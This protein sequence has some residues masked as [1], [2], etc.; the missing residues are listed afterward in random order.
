LTDQV[1]SVHVQA[2]Q[3]LLKYQDHKPYL[4]RRS[5]LQNALRKFSQGEV[6]YSK[7]KDGCLIW[8][9]WKKKAKGD[10]RYRNFPKGIQLPPESE[11]LYDFYLHSIYGDKKMFYNNLIH[12]IKK[13]QHPGTK[14]LLV[15]L[16]EDFQ[17]SGEKLKRDGELTHIDMSLFLK[18]SSLNNLKP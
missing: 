13:I 7:V 17:Q 18:D 16:D 1:E 2:Y 9:A 6:L 5:L 12:S 11:I 14:H 15:C 3:D 10:F 8:F 4:T